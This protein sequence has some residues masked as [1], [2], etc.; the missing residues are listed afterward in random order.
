MVMDVLSTFQSSKRYSINLSRRNKFV[1]FGGSLDFLYCRSKLSF[2]LRVL[3]SASSSSSTSLAWTAVRSP[4]TPTALS[5]NMSSAPTLSPETSV[6]NRNLGWYVMI[7]WYSRQHYLRVIWWFFQSWGKIFSQLETRA[8]LSS[9][10]RLVEVLVTWTE[11]MIK[12]SLNMHLVPT[13]TT[14]PG[15]G[16]FSVRCSHSLSSWKA[17]HL[18]HL[19]DYSMFES[20][21]PAKRRSSPRTLSP[22]GG[23][24]GE[25]GGSRAVGPKGG[26]Q[27]WGWG[28]RGLAN[29]DWDCS[30][31]CLSWWW[32][33]AAPWPA[34]TCPPASS[35]VWCTPRTCCAPAP[36]P[37][38]AT[39]A[40]CT[41]LFYFYCCY[42][43]LYD[44]RPSS[45]IIF[46]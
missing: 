20:G 10:E 27:G 32:G 9:I 42:P 17:W 36:P 3:S 24:W 7:W 12:P 6:S 26:K 34:P 37:V 5:S 35:P 16:R 1:H 33:N 45:G 25:W 31:F 29:E 43:H 15:H 22:P 38:P 44:D 13:C 30:N 41:I 4:S 21:S 2:L 39:Q 23:C 28:E 11:M 8:A 19:P 18:W 14:R 40:N 46:L